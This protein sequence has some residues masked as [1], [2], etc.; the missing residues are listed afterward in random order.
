[1]SKFTIY[2]L[3]MSNISFSIYAK[4]LGTDGNTFS[5]KELH[6]LEYIEHLLKKNKFEIEE[7]IK[8]YTEQV[9][10]AIIT[11][12]AVDGITNTTEEREYTWDP[13]Y[14]VPE[15]LYDEEGNILTQAGLK[16]NSQD[17]V[18]L[19]RKYIFID[20]NNDKHVEFARGFAEKDKIILING[21][22]NEVAEK[23]GKKIYFDQE[24]VLTK[25]FGIKHAPAVV[26]AQDK[27]IYIKEYEVDHEN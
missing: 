25:K 24:G 4:D 1:M 11:P 14:T 19:T 10:K 5:I 22:P 27:M 17:Y 13:V 8:Q 26:R 23:L 7:K 15:T 3:I 9:K 16:Y 12:K 21:Q 6:F 2:F 20:G 18:P